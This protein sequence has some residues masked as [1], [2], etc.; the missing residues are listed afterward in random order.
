[1]RFQEPLFSCVFIGSLGCGSE[2]LPLIFER[3]VCYHPLW[4]DKPQIDS[5]SKTASSLK[6]AGKPASEVFFFL[7]VEPLWEPTAISIV[8]DELRCEVEF[9]RSVH[10][11]GRP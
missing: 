9:L 4:Q 8:N 5:G 3:A 6:I 2:V 10:P 7:R 11:T 1:M